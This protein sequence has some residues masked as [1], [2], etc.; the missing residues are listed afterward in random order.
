MKTVCFSVLSALFTLQN[1]CAQMTTFRTQFNVTGESGYAIHHAA[2]SDGGSVCFYNSYTNVQQTNYITIIKSDSA[3]AID[4]KLRFGPVYP[5]I[6]NIVQAADSGYFFT[7]TEFSGPGWTQVIRLDKNGSIVYSRRFE[8]PPSYGISN[9]AI[10]LPKA[11]GHVYVASNLFNVSNSTYIWH[12]YEL[13][14]AGT[15]L[16]QHGYNP[17]SDK[18]YLVDIDSCSNGD[19][20]IVG[21]AFSFQTSDHSPLVTRITSSGTWL[22]SNIYEYTGYD[23]L[24]VSVKVAPGDNIVVCSNE[25]YT[26]AQQTAT[27]LMRCN[28]AGTEQWTYRYSVVNANLEAVSVEVAEDHNTVVIANEKLHG[29]FMKN[30]TTGLIVCTRLYPYILMQSMDTCAGA[31]YN[32]S[33]YDMTT[34]KGLLF[35]SDLCGSSCLD[36]SVVINKL[37]ITVTPQ[38][39][40]GDIATTMLETLNSIP[41]PAVTIH[42]EELCNSVG[43]TETHESPFSTFPNP[44]GDVLH[45][46]SL[47]TFR[48]IEL[49]NVAGEAV[50][51]E[52]PDAHSATLDVSGLPCGVYFLR[53]NGEVQ[54]QKIV[55]AR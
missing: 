20:V 22:W 35:N 31:G 1:V 46:Q 21:S 8:A 27:F 14:A 43:V 38:A 51:L 6:G 30:D 42:A 55:I 3:G 12:V 40:V 10:L 11:N 23:V 9:H 48:S 24:P 41:T 36:S 26:V 7:Y 47:Q 2:T 19:L 33:A 15:I 34:M 49:V 37:H 16:W 18:N 17:T 45:V 29:V 52:L 39:T 25:Y 54:A 32:F 50:L 28:S 44:V 13:D 53:V 4:W 5:L